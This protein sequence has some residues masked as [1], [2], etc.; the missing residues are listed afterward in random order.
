MIRNE[1]YQNYIGG[2]WVKSE[3]SETFHVYNPAH[4]RITIGTLQLSGKDDA[5]KAVEAA[6]EAFPKWRSTPAP[7]RGKILFR[8]ASVLQETSKN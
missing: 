1:E 2:K 3:S 4:R 8:A 6:R 5:A 7:D